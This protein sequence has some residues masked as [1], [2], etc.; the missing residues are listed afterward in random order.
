MALLKMQEWLKK[1]YIDKE[2]GTMD[3]PKAAESF[4]NGTSGIMFG[5]AWSGDW[6]LGDLT[7]NIPGAVMVAAPLPSGPDGTIGRKSG[8]L[9]GYQGLFFS[10]DFQNIEAF[11]KVFDK[12]YDPMF[13][14]GDFKN[15][16]AEGY[17][18]I[19]KD[20]Q[21]LYEESQIPGGK[22]YN[23]AK[24]TFAGNQP[25]IPYLKG[26]IYKSLFDGKAPLTPLEIALATT[27]KVTIQGYTVDG[28]MQK[29]DIGTDFTGA[30]TETMKTRNDI[31]YKM[32]VEAF[33]KIIYGKASA[34]SFDTFVKDWLSNGGEKITQEV[35]EWY[36]AS[37]GQ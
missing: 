4:A 20:G 14:E 15:G 24:Y 28:E 2:A 8:P 27:P 26:E 37:V 35:N 13:Q 11:F 6:P 12:I 21:P 34:D 31:L 1:G 29:Y 36:K 3:G 7:K 23:V 19:L 5:P 17:D 18:Y 25:G 32:E 10:K 22:K 30:P 9:N 16:F 33:L